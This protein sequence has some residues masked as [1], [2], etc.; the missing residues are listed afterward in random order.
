LPTE[1]P[2][3][4]SSG[5]AETPSRVASHH[6][7]AGECGLRRPRSCVARPLAVNR[8]SS[9]DR[10]R[11]GRPC[12]IR[13]RPGLRLLVELALQPL[14]RL[15]GFLQPLFEGVLPRLGREPRCSRSAK[16]ESQPQ[17]DMDRHRRLLRG[18]VTCLTS[19]SVGAK[20]VRCKACEEGSISAPPRWLLV[21]RPA[22]SSCTKHCM[23]SLAERG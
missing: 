23:L 3:R 16:Q 2:R 15:L 19:Q 4:R 6:P 21:W 8:R 7:G 9:P 18:C 5:S 20:L 11:P 1:F 17:A 12:R 22:R 14:D 13:C 10:G